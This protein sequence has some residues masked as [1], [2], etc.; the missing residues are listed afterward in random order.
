MLTLRSSDHIRTARHLKTF[1]SRPS[2]TGHPMLRAEAKRACRE[3]I[4]LAGRELRR[5]WLRTQWT[6]RFAREARRLR[7]LPP[8]TLD[9]KREIES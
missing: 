2:C 3:A 4:H 8:S 6:G 5:L 9:F 1:R 7:V